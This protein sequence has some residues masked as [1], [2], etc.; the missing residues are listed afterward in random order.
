[1]TET[2]RVHFV[3]F[4]V[5]DEHGV[6][7]SGVRYKQVSRELDEEIEKSNRAKRGEATNAKH[8]QDQG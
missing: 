5:L 3:G 2:L 4:Q 1:M 6:P 8:R 7:L